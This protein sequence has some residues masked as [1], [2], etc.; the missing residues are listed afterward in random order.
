MNRKEIS[1]RLRIAEK[2]FASWFP[3]F[4]E[5]R[6]SAAHAGELAEDPSKKERRISRA[7]RQSDKFKIQKGSPMIE[8]GSLDGDRLTYTLEDRIIS[9]DI[10]P[11]TW[12][13]LENIKTK[14]FDAFH[15]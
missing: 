12:K 4:E 1:K 10:T 7:G 2:L 9:Y 6:H 5:I 11:E 15:A 3:D 13:K 8:R 14:I